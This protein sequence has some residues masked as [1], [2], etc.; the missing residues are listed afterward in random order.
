[1][2]RGPFPC[3]LRAAAGPP[4]RPAEERPVPELPVGRAVRQGKAQPEAA[5][6]VRS[7]VRGAAPLARMAAVLVAA[8]LRVPSA[9][10]DVAR[11]ARMAEA[12]AAVAPRAPV[13][14]RGGA[15]LGRAAEGRAEGAGGAPSA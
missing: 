12:R 15:P 1:L 6:R 10:R 14:V 4:A 7:A 9:G 8:A 11:V 13:A 2:R 3:F 5:L